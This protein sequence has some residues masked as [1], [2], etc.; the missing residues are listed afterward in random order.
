MELFPLPLL[1]FMMRSSPNLEKLKLLKG[2]WSTANGDSSS[3][4]D[5]STE[6]E[7]APDIWLEHM[8]EFE[9]KNFTNDKYE[10]AFVRLILAKSPVLKKVSIVLHYTVSNEAETPILR[11]LL[12]YPRASPVA[13]ITVV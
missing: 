8:K 12:S 3:Y 1:A 7:D 2:A 13:V 11:I 4:G 5:F 9:F 10:L 6:L